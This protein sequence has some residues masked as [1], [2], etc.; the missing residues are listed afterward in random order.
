MGDLRNKAKKEAQDAA[1]SDAHDRR[2]HGFTAFHFD[3]NP[4]LTRR[5]L[6]LGEAIR[7]LMRVTGTRI[8]FWRCPI[9][10]LAIQYKKLPTTSY[11][12]DNGE[13]YMVLHFCDLAD[14][15][16]AKRVLVLDMLLSGIEMYRGWPNIL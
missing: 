2:R 3:F 10:G 5:N 15:A 1:V 12:H 7:H 4:K 13:T 8:S 9:R 14:K 16:E 6:T 11:S